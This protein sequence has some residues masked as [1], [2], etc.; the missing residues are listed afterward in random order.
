[1]SGLGV[2]ETALA[3]QSKVFGEKPELVCCRRFRTPDWLDHRRGHLRFQTDLIRLEVCA[4]ACLFCVANLRFSKTVLS[5]FAARWLARRQVTEIA[6]SQNLSIEKRRL[7]RDF[8][9]TA[10]VVPPLAPRLSA[11]TGDFGMRDFGG[12]AGCG[13]RNTEAGLRWKG[14]NAGRE[15]RNG[16][17][18]ELG[19]SKRYPDA[20]T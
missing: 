4:L 12:Q 15:N 6:T 11:G 7:V 14:Q 20:R 8:S 2:W 13:R 3:T 5:E 19:S 10:E 16:Q 1:M 18:N 9:G 17:L